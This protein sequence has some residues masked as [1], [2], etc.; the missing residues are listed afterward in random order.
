MPGKS[1]PQE[2]FW[3]PYTY[4]QVDKECG[5][6]RKMADGSACRGE[7]GKLLSAN[8]ATDARKAT[9][10][11]ATNCVDN[12]VR[13]Y[14][15]VDKVGVR[16]DWYRWRLYDPRVRPWYTEVKQAWEKKDAAGR[17]TALDE[18]RRWSQ[19]Y[20]FSTSGALGITANDVLLT[21][22][23][24]G[25]TWLLSSTR[26][27][28]R[29]PQKRTRAPSPEIRRSCAGHHGKPC[30]FA[31]TNAPGSTASVRHGSW[32]RASDGGASAMPESDS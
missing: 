30:I 29:A 18:T 24:K 17:R 21:R 27:S 7:T 28:C 4:Q 31:H 20:T 25:S 13:S 10:D 8:C 2:M 19:V 22:D 26:P 14:Y 12:N 6:D 1:R 32:V 3:S 23:A 15:T 11:F 5:A 16:K 9:K